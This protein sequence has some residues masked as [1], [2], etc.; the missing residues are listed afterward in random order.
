MWCEVRSAEGPHDWDQQLEAFPQARDS[1]PGGPNVYSKGMLYYR[2]ETTLRI[3]VTV[4]GIHSHSKTSNWIKCIRITPIQGY[5]CC[6]EHKC[7]PYQYSHIQ[8]PP[9]YQGFASPPLSTM[10]CVSVRHCLANNEPSNFVGFS[11]RNECIVKWWIIWWSVSEN[12][13]K[14][15][16]AFGCLKWILL[17]ALA[18]GSVTNLHKIYKQNHLAKC[19]R[20]Q[21]IFISA[22]GFYISLRYWASKK[23]IEY[24]KVLRVK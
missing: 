15:V 16:V 10:S 13:K 3:P 4:S 8:Y 24:C 17:E 6:T 11:S 14:I 21:W 12:W 23:C 20:G 5:Q 19:W 22:Y 9:N 7:K 2:L 1:G 18:L